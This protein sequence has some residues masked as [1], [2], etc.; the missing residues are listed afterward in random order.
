M[1]RSIKPF[2]TLISQITKQV[3]LIL[4][5]A[6]ISTVIAQ[7]PATPLM[8]A[9]SGSP[10][11]LPMDNCPPLGNETAQVMVDVDSTLARGAPGWDAPVVT[12]LIKFQCFYA[13]GKDSRYG[14]CW[15]AKATAKFG[16]MGKMCVGVAASM[17][18]L[19]PT[20]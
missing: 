11:A 1:N 15:C 2:Q 5:L 7:G 20:M 4:S 17:R 18:C 13:I 14:F 9:P 10:L 19:L 6:F 8:A 16:Y 12:R 3:R